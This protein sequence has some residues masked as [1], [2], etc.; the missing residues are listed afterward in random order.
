[1][2]ATGTIY[3][4]TIPAFAGTSLGGTAF[5]TKTDGTKYKFQ[6]YN[7]Y[8]S[9][10]LSQESLPT[11]RQY[12][13]QQKDKTGLYYY[14]ARYYDP[15]L[16]QFVSPDTLVPYPTSV[17]SYNRFLYTQANPINRV[18]P[19]GHTDCAT[20]CNPSV[21]QSI[22]QTVMGLGAAAGSMS[23]AGPAVA[24][25]VVA[26]AAAY[27]NSTW[28][29]PEYPAIYPDYEVGE[30]GASAPF[31]G[32]STVTI[33]DMTSLVPPD[34]GSAIGGF[35]PISEAGSS[36]FETSGTYEFPDL[37]NP[38]KT[39]VGQSGNVESR[40]QSHKRNGRLTDVQGAA[41]TEVLG[42]KFDREIAEQNRINELGG[43]VGGTVSNRRNPIG[44]TRED[45][46]LQ[47][48]LNEPAIR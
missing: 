21:W 24:V 23:P 1:M 47:N 7:A 20:A 25:T 44:A 40:L 30:I 48:G 39:Y 46:A 41:I 45:R 37:R 14:N 6:A 11:D 4:T 3:T 26:S 8:G 38:G 42:G 32:S 34:D 18:D 43:L 16:G 10:R 36:I 28:D 15:Q 22:W 5:V 9:K 17:L 31:P 12:T 27:E 19:T 29:S 13:G 35:A 2:A 33:P